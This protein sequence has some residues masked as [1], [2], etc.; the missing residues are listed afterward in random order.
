MSN[1]KNILSSF[2]L[3]NTLN[4]KI[5]ELSDKDKDSNNTPNNYKIYPEVRERL[6]EIAYR[7]IDS[8]DI[9][10]VIDDIII[11]GSL[12]NFNWS[13]FSDVDLHVLINF[14]QFPEK[15]RSLYVEL[16]DLKKVLFNLKYNIKVKGFDVEL[17][18]Q[19]KSVTSFSS[20]VY[21]VLFDKWES[22]PNKEKVEIDKEAILNKTNQWTQ[23][24]DSAIEE[25][26]DKNLED[27]LKILNKFKDK[28]KKYRTSG[29]EEGGEYSNENLVFKALR[30]NGYIGKLYDFKNKLMSNKL[31]LTEQ[32]LNDN[33]EIILQSPLE[34]NLNYKKENGFKSAAR[35]TH[36]GIDF[37]A[38][39]G[40]NIISPSDG[41]VIDA[42]IR[43]A[44]GGTLFIDHKNGFKSRYCHV[45][46]FYADMGDKVTQGQIVGLSGGDSN[47]KGRGN[48]TGAHLHF[49][50][51][52]DGKLVDPMDYLDKSGIDTDS[53]IKNEL[54][55]DA[56]KSEFLEKLKSIAN[57]DKTFKNLKENGKRIPYDPDVEIIQTSLQFLGFLLPKW[58]VDGKFGP[59]TE[60]SSNGFKS[61]YLPILKKFKHLIS[62][63]KNVLTSD[64]IKVIYASLLE[65]G[66]EES[67]LTGI[68]KKSDFSKMDIGD[69]KEFYEQILNCVGAPITDENLKFLYAWRQAEGGTA[70]NNPFNT[71]WRLE[72]S[73]N[74]GT[75]SAK[76]QEYQTPQDG[77]GA[78]CKTL[79]LGYYTCIVEGL[80]NDIGAELISTKC[81][82]SL[83]TWGTHA[84][85]PLITKILQSN[86]INPPPIG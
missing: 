5:W 41:V 61:K 67:D 12:V 16:L 78:T 66:F 52:K 47:D 1:L 50:L 56:E 4:L 23:I 71:T 17:Y 7:F 70:G 26:S 33:D 32:D 80:I 3:R 48:S 60:A 19:D 21:S 34:G 43:P 53:E 38:K 22:F 20:G 55:T 44:C 30:R 8:F 36:P 15:H 24:I 6:L 79:K 63:E 27:G 35:N 31:S 46:T 11:T 29:L 25:A 9:D 68:Q 77:L 51:Y 37:F 40:S 82:S 45:K 73:T 75:N 84:S 54:V 13:K 69:D 10:V 74:Y 85:N 18:A 83:K 72:N 62:S 28:L 58:G 39:S 86:N 2:K 65:E 57:S 76:V 64:D 59:E 42:K 14:K 81:N 49:E